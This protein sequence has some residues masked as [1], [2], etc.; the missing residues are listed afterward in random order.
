MEHHRLLTN[1]AS[2]TLNRWAWIDPQNQGG[3]ELQANGHT[4]ADNTALLVGLVLQ[5]LGI[6]RIHDL[7]ALPLVRQG[8]LVPILQAYFVS[9]QVPIY[10]VILQ[11]RHWL[12]KIRACIDY[13]AQWMADGSKSSP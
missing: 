11:E 2:P 9:P 3:G 4:R 10:A 7:S 1:S 6:A 12:P 5:G 8:R 13:W